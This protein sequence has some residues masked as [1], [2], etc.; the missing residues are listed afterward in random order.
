MLEDE[1][2]M[3]SGEEDTPRPAP[4]KR[5]RRKAQE[6]EKTDEENSHP[7]AAPRQ[8]TLSVVGET[9]DTP[10]GF[11]EARKAVHGSKGVRGRTNNVIV[12]IPVCKSS[13]LEECQ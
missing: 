7:A 2:D 12:E 9:T 10:T 13:R 1:E 4:R 3:A 11:R 8:A 5:A 6:G